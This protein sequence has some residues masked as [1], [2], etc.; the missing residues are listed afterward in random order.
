[1]HIQTYIQMYTVTHAHV[2]THIHIHTLEAHTNTH[3]GDVNKKIGSEFHQ[4][5]IISVLKQ[6]ERERS[7]EEK[8]EYLHSTDRDKQMK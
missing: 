8:V 7:G 5:L 6:R 2:D 3:A 4:R 1:M